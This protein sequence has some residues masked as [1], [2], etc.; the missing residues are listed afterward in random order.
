MRIKE[1]AEGKGKSK[2]EEERESDWQVIEHLIIFKIKLHLKIK[3][4]YY[5][6]N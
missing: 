1:L 4:N 2:V 6:K 5:L 3:K